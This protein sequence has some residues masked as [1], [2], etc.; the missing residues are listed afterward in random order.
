VAS[1]VGAADVDALG[2][3]GIEATNVVG[4]VTT[5]SLETLS[6][7]LQAHEIVQP[8]IRPFSLADAGDALAAVGTG[9]VRGKIVVTVA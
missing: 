1:A 9:H 4:S 5:A 7:M 3:R 2:A 8:E 6:E